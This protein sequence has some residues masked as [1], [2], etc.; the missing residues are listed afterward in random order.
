MNDYS[1]SLACSFFPRLVSD[2]LSMLNT[3]RDDPDFGSTMGTA[4][5]VRLTCLVV[6][7]PTPL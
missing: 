5:R 2:F 7:C 6:L 1:D 3:T 4:S